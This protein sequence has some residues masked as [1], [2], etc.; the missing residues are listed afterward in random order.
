MAQMGGFW[1]ALTRPRRFA[2]QKVRGFESHHPLLETRWKRR[3]FVFSGLVR[4]LRSAR[5]VSF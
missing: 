4:A 2:M 1:V 3:V 5:K